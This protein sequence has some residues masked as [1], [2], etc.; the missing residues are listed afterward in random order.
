MF[1]IQFIRSIT[2]RT[3]KKEECERYYGGPWGLIPVDSTP[4]RALFRGTDSGHHI[5][6]LLKANDTG[7]DKICLA[8]DTKD[9]VLGA[10]QA[11]EAAGYE[12]LSVAAELASM[13]GGF[14]FTTVD[15]DGNKIEISCDVTKH[16]LI[17]DKPELLERISHMLLNSPSMKPMLAFYVDLLGFTI[18]DTYEN[19]CMVFLRC[20]E[21]HHCIVIGEAPVAGIQHIAFDVPNYDALMCGVG[22]LRKIGIDPLWGVGR[23]G[24][25]G[26]IF[27]YFADPNGYVVEI[28]CELL[29][30]SDDYEPQAWKRCAENGDIWGS[31]GAPSDEIKKL[32]LGDR[33]GFSLQYTESSD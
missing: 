20:N 9:E 11:V 16:E 26:N 7:L 18:S 21:L 13:G 31:A 17:E 15:P 29:Q 27:A 25:G 1:K 14:G 6:Q 30:P 2:L 33:E 10:A 23:H 24:P 19:D 32:W 28:T 22:R 4:E 3:T 8:V 12:I 5:L